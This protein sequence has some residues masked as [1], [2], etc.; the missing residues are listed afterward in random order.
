MNEQRPGLFSA[1]LQTSQNL[2]RRNSELV[3]LAAERNRLINRYLTSVQDCLSGSIYE[4]PPLN[5]LG[6]DQFDAHLREYGWD[7]PSV[8]HT[9]IGKKRL[10]NV[11]ALTES[12]LGNHIQGDLIETGVWRGG[13][14]ILMRAVLDAYCVTDRRVWVADSFEGLPPPDHE[15]YPADTGDTFHTYDELS[16]PMEQVMRNFEKYGLLDEQVVFLKG[17]FKDTL[18]TAPIEKLALLRLDGDMY[19][20]TLD[21]LS[22][23]YDKVSSG[24]YV[25][26]DD[27]NVVPAC[28]QAVHDFLAAREFAPTL[29]EIDGVGV[30]WQVP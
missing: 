14:C 30:Y 26:V 11:R 9:M 3:Y 21:A 24:G 17:W 22:A 7:W 27:Y 6:H 28:K 18:T 8:A 25:I 29:V 16:V 19:E 2:F 10:A 23:L 15:K 1:L 12:V 20:S 13:A 5:V 4:D